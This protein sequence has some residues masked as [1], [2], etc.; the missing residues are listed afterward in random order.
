M[1]QIAKG[2]AD[3]MMAHAREAAPRE[4]CGLLVGTTAG[5]D[6]CVP[7]ANVDPHPSRFQI[8]P[9]EHFRLI[10]RL[11]G[12]NQTIVGAYHSHPRSEA[13]P[14]PTDLAEASDPE[15]LYIIVSLAPSGGEGIRAY[16]IEGGVATTVPL[17]LD[18]TGR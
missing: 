9:A 17:D 16:R 8:D 1:V 7:T 11:R 12:S 2:V 18:A 13:T 3:A 14:S 15:F 4:C 5:I 6:E 10:R